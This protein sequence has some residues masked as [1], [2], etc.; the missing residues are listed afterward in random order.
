[1]STSGFASPEQ[2]AASTIAVFSHNL[3]NQISGIALLAEFLERSGDALSPEDRADAVH[4]LA[5]RSQAT[6]ELL[7]AGMAGCALGWPDGAATPSA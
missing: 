1:M 3:L 6:V 2:V 4:K 5:A 7:R